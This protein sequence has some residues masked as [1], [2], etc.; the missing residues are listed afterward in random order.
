ME[1]KLGEL[2]QPPS[3]RFKYLQIAVFARC[4]TSIG[5]IPSATAFCGR[6]QISF[7]L[8]K[9]FVKDDGNGWD[10]HYRNHQTASRGKP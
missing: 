3:R 9:K 2:Q 1:L 8:K 7:Q 6:E 10:I 5:R 4:S